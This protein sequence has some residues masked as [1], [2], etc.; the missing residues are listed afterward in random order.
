MISYRFLPISSG[1]GV[2]FFETPGISQHF[3][4]IA[5]GMALLLMVCVWSSVGYLKF[6]G[7]VL[8]T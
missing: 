5:V 8:L 1:K 6:L 7:I 4:S 3:I 2:L